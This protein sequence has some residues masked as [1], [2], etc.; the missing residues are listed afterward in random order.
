MRYTNP[1]NCV[2]TPI[3]GNALTLASVKKVVV[4]PQT[5]ALE[6]A[7]GFD[8]LPRVKTIVASAPTIEVESQC[9]SAFDRVV[10]GTTGTLSWVEQSPKGQAVAGG[11]GRR[12]TAAPVIYMGLRQDSKFRKLRLSVVMF[13]T[14]S[15]DG[16]TYPIIAED[17]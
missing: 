3:I 6:L 12:Y 4:N 2:F 17:V 16:A 15:P 14:Y 1:S 10:F 13:A 5:R 7:G 9:A 11:G 8:V